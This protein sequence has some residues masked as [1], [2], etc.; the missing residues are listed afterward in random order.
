[1]LLGN[2]C[3]SAALRMQPNLE[4][5]LQ[6]MFMSQMR[7]G[8]P[9]LEGELE[10]VLTNREENFAIRDIKTIAEILNAGAL[11]K[12]ESS[13]QAIESEMATVQ[14]KL[15][16][17]QFEILTKEIEY[18]KKAAIVWYSKLTNHAASIKCTRDQWRSDVIKSN[19]NAAASYLNSICSLEVYPDSPGVILD[20]AM[21]SYRKMKMDMVQR[22]S[23]DVG[24]V[25]TV[26][27]LNYSTPTVTTTHTMTA[28]AQLARCIVH[29][30]PNNI[31][32]RFEPVFAYKKGQVYAAQHIVLN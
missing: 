27:L 12:V 20:S 19:D 22:L 24:N 28:S 16:K 11:V 32:I 6:E 4:A 8:A 30:S 31:G 9:Q 14:L 17:E 2:P 5:P 7:Q 15:D 1:M 25:L 13:V 21:A 23:I 18:D 3:F 29:E 26:V 10:S